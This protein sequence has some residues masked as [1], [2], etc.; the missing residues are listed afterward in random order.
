MVIV[1]AI[2]EDGYT[3]RLPVAPQQC[4]FDGATFSIQTKA[5]SVRREG[6]IDRLRFRSEGTDETVEMAAPRKVVS[7]NTFTALLDVTI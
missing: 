6:T 1:D 5:V 4:H 7:G 2:Y 3:L